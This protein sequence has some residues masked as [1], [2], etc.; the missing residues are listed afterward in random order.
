[1]IEIT[2]VLPL[3]PA[4]GGSVAIPHKNTRRL[5]DG[6]SLLFRAVE[7][8]KAVFGWAVVSTDDTDTAELAARMKV[9]VVFRQVTGDG[10]M[11]AVVREAVELF[12]DARAVALL[13]PTAPLRSAES[14]ASAVELFTN[15][16]TAVVSVSPIPAKFSR[17]WRLRI[18]NGR[19]L[20]EEG[21]WSTIPP[22]RQDI[23]PCEFVR[24]GSLYLTRAATVRAG[25]LYGDRVVPWI[26]PEN[27]RLN[28]DS[29]E[30]WA[31]LEARLR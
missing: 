19:L 1:M 26:T 13:Q 27:E 8:A 31:A 22:R 25:S 18:V 21:D 10:P 16:A 14:I 4:R 20:T 6:T 23:Q 9:S 17:P 15:E 2:D 24:D 3:V 29:W 12:P 11:L 7:V 5:S 28:I 30:D